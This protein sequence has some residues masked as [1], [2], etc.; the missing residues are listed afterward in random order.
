MNFGDL[1]NIDA[2]YIRVA[3]KHKERKELETRIL[4]NLANPDYMNAT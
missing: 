4:R 3:R 2:D 1:A